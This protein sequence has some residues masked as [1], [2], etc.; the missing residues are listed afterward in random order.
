MKYALYYYETRYYIVE[1]SK[2]S[3][4]AL[5][6]CQVA[7]SVAIVSARSYDEAFRHLYTIAL[8]HFLKTSPI[9]PD[10]ANILPNS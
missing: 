9:L 1:L 2:L 5:A 4:L 8:F 6:L 10:H 7:K 3:P